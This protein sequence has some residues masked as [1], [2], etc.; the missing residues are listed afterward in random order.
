MTWTMRERSHAPQL[1]AAEGRSERLEAQ[2][3]KRKDSASAAATAKNKVV[4]TDVSWFI[5]LTDHS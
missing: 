1:S 2:P 4:Q 5:A 3:L